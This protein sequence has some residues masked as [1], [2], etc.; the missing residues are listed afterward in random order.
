ML[1]FLGISDEQRTVTTVDIDNIRANYNVSN[2]NASKSILRQSGMVGAPASNE[3][4]MVQ[5]LIELRADGECRHY[6]AGTLIHIHK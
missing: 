6:L 1:P 5:G 2:L 3:G 4:E